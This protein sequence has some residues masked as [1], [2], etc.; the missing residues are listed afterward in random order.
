MRTQ[1]LAIVALLAAAPLCGG[2]QPTQPQKQ[3]SLPKATGGTNSFGEVFGRGGGATTAGPTG[4][5][6]TMGGA[7]G[8]GGGLSGSLDEWLARALRS[9]PDLKVAE[10]KLREA[11]AEL[12]RVRLQIMQKIVK[13]Q[14]DVKEAKEKV[15]QLTTRYERMKDLHKQGVLS[16][17]E[18]GNAEGELLAAKSSLARLEGELPFLLGQQPQQAATFLS[19]FTYLDIDRMPYGVEIITRGPTMAGSAGTMTTGTVPVAGSA[20]DKVRKALDAPI[21]LKY[22]DAT[23]EQIVDDFRRSAKG[24]NFIVNAAKGTKLNVDLGPIPLGAAMQWF[25]DETHLRFV[26]REYGIVAVSPTKAPPGAVG[27]VEYW[28]SGNRPTTMSSPG[29][30]TTPSTGGERIGAPKQ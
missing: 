6:T 26:L 20:P 10:S 2:Q 27:V 13:L 16:V 5:T 3:Q 29:G 28:R 30:N 19:G 7:T 17:T 21:T 9:N 11:E 4:S 22:Q 12:N 14:Y 15:A 18:F 24:I 25:E 23:P 8:M 1:S